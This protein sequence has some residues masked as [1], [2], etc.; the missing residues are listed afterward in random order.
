MSYDSI[1]EWL[2]NYDE[3]MLTAVRNCTLENLFNPGQ[4]QGITFLLPSKRGNRDARRD[5]IEKSSSED[6]SDKVQALN[7]IAAL[8]IFDNLPSPDIFKSRADNIPNGLNQHVQIDLARCT[9]NTIQFTNGATAELCQEF[10]KEC[11]KKNLNVY[12]L[13][14][15]LINIDGEKA[16][17]KNII[18][19][20]RKAVEKPET[21]PKNMWGDN[22]TVTNESVALR[23]KITRE[24]EN[25]YMMENIARSTLRSSSNRNVYLERVVSLIDFILTCCSEQAIAEVF[26]GKMLPLLSFEHIDFYLFFEPYKQSGTYLIPT[27]IIRRYVSYSESC[28]MVA[29]IKRI[30]ACFDSPSYTSDTRTLPAVLT[31]RFDLQV[32]VD[33]A[34]RDELISNTDDRR[35]PERICDIYKKINAN[36]SINQ[37]VANIL[38]AELHS[39]YQTRPALKLCQDEA[40]YII[41]RKFEEIESSVFDREV[42]R[43]TL[44]ILRRYLADDFTENSL[45]LLNPVTLRHA[46]QPQNKIREIRSFINSRFFMFFPLSKKEFAKFADG[47]EV[48]THPCPDGEGLWFP[49]DPTIALVENYRKR[50]TYDESSRGFVS[51]A[52]RAMNILDQI[53]TQGRTLDAATKQKLKELLLDSEDVIKEVASATSENASSSSSSSASTSQKK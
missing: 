33:S 34:L 21:Q 28:N 49:V 36:N 30:E 10:R 43:E 24:T 35:L 2:E 5:L 39:V 22:L 51:D 18:N 44:E 1:L 16:K 15:G 8:V 37:A 12:L 7:Q 52:Q 25:L 40:R 38:P 48:K 27:D 4:K 20:R 53:K 42:Y 13:H 41:H 14:N 9:S 45:K 29:A 50:N 47:Y 32:N 23:E 26:Y 31:S 3:Q 17:N 46:I 6:T 19:P 11:T